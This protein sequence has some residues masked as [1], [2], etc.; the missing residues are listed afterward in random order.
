MV[1]LDNARPHNSRKSIECLEQ[2]HAH[3]VPHPAYSLDFAPSV[4]FLFRYLKSKHLG[5]VIRSREDLL[6]EIGRIFQEILKETF[7]SV[8]ASWKQSIKWVIKNRGGV[9]P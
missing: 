7:I 2:F 6:S 1:H 4:F 9:L 3:R 5:L 8:Y